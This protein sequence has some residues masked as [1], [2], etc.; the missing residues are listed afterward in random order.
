M[1]FFGSL[2]DERG[3]CCFFQL[4][5]IIDSE[6]GF[7]SSTN[8]LN[9][10]DQL[11]GKKMRKK[12]AEQVLQKFVQNKWLIEVVWFSQ[13]GTFR[14]ENSFSL[15][16]YRIQLL[17][18]ELG[19]IRPLVCFNAHW[20]P[21]RRTWSLP[22]ARVM[23]PGH[24]GQKCRAGTAPGL[25]LWSTDVGPWALWVRAWLWHQTRPS[26]WSGNLELLFCRRGGTVSPP[27]GR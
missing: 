17:S 19:P 27:G 26:S 22:L 18:V 13:P 23:W 16:P 2:I 25:A 3:T 15:K 7:A 20:D 6:T 21:M 1:L 4:E 9:L 24:P 10:V 11:K 12:E 8:I 14:T 5:L